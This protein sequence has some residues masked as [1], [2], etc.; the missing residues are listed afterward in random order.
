[1]ALAR[2]AALRQ[3]AA[4]AQ[5]GLAALSAALSASAALFSG[6]PSLYQLADRPLPHTAGSN[7]GYQHHWS[8]ASA[9]PGMQ[10]MKGT[11]SQPSLHT[12]MWPLLSLSS[13]RRI[14]R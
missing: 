14:R 13:L 4:R 6:E 2:L 5:A 9:S 11:A 8:H 7:A 1:M 3:Q 12:V 10:P